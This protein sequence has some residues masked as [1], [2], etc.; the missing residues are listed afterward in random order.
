MAGKSGAAK[1]RTIPYHNTLQWYTRIVTSETCA[2]CKSQCARGIE[3]MEQMSKPGAVGRG[4]PCVL[5]AYKI[6]PK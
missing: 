6:S 4:V 2:V 1:R 5:T 3:Y